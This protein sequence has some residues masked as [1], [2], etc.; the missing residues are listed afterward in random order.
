M[1]PIDFKDQKP[2]LIIE[3]YLSGDVKAWVFYKID[4]V[5]SQDNSQRI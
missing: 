1:E 3:D 2:R 4:Q 5:K